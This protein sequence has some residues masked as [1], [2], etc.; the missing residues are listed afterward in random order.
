MQKFTQWIEKS[1]PEYQIDEGIL[2]NIAAGAAMTAGSLFG[3]NH[4]SAAEPVPMNAPA[5][6]P[7]ATSLPDLH[8]I[9]FINPIAIKSTDKDYIKDTSRQLDNMIQ[10][11]YHDV[12]LSDF[13]QKGGKCEVVV[14][15]ITPN[16]NEI[17][18]LPNT[19]WKVIPEKADKQGVRM[20]NLTVKIVFR[21]GDGRVVKASDVFPLDPLTKNIVNSGK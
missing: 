7:S 1:H 13:G 8:D 14:M 6:A 20:T 12:A 10:K 17:R 9:Q 18:I 15:G 16:K 11:L 3:G 19:I 2:R 5:I 4:A 21:D